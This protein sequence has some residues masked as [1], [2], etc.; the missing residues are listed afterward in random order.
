MANPEAIMPQPNFNL[1]LAQEE[2]A[3]QGEVKLFR[4]VSLIWLSQLRKRSCY[5]LR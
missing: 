4:S 5:L 3:L 2:L 1:P